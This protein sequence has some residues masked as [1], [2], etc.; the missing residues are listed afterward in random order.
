MCVVKIFCWVVET[1]V[2]SRQ[3]VKNNFTT[4][5]IIYPSLSSSFR[6][7]ARIIALACLYKMPQLVTSAI[8]LH[9]HTT[10]IRERGRCWGPLVVQ[11][12]RRDNSMEYS[13]FL[14]YLVVSVLLRYFCRIT[15]T[16]NRRMDNKSMNDVCFNIY[17][18]VRNIILSV[19]TLK[20]FKFIQWVITLAMRILQQ[21]KRGTAITMNLPT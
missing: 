7:I 21:L 2:S 19:L 5:I 17:Y 18:V 4:I 15:T 9:I 3:V 16:I 13:F 10:H 20:N 1:R 8:P 6:V 12:I 14:L 11:T